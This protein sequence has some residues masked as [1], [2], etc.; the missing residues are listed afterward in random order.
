M[1][2]ADRHRNEDS[3]R[4]FPTGTGINAHNF[5]CIF[6]DQIFTSLAERLFTKVFDVT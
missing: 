4:L 6:V 5:F 1:T 3:S 2:I